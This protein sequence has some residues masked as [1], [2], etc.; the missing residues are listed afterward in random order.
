MSSKQ[1]ELKTQNRSPTRYCD[2][3]SRCLGTK[4]MVVEVSRHGRAQVSPVHAL[5]P[6]SPMCVRGHAG[7]TNYA[8]EGVRL[9]PRC[10]RAETQ[11]SA[12]DSSPPPPTTSRETRV[13]QAQLARRPG[14]KKSQEQSQG[15]AW[16]S[17]V[18]IRSF[19]RKCRR[20]RGGACSGLVQSSGD[21]QPTRLWTPK[22]LCG[23]TIALG[24]PGGGLIRQ[25]TTISDSKVNSESWVGAMAAL[26]TGGP[27]GRVG[28]V[29]WN[30]LVLY[31]I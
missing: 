28:C 17:T 25:G 22:T 31:T 1:N 2:D 23:A 27:L 30:G 3:C 26:P 4:T 7:A 13:M 6:G 5:L 9:G 18:V 16:G 21:R 20:T 15:G 19:R 12:A 29:Q 10:S 8:I 11:V 14:S 24:R